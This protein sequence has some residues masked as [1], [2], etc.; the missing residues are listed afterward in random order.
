ML[1]K[2]KI[3]T[4]D[5]RQTVM[6]DRKENL[7]SILGA[8][9]PFSAYKEISERQ[10]LEPKDIHDDCKEIKTNGQ[11]KNDIKIDMEQELRQKTTKNEKSPQTYA[12]TMQNTA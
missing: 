1:T 3:A 11:T 10:K 4:F 12:I 5:V 8:L 7:P 9:T 6:L 2:I